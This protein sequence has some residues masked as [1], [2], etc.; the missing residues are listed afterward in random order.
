M[1]NK[2]LTPGVLKTMKA[3]G[4]L[5][6]INE[7]LELRN[8][9]QVSGE[10]EELVDLFELGKENQDFRELRNRLRGAEYQLKYFESR[11]MDQEAD[12]L[13]KEINEFK[14]KNNI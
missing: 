6:A 11:N 14:I 9:P 4:T 12:E 1:N 10:Q 3:Y 7:E 13:R 2:N 8:T 5:E